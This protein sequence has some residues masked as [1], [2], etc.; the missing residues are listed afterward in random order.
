MLLD[1]FD[2]LLQAPSFGRSDFL[3]RLARLQQVQ[4]ASGPYALRT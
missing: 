3:I 1:G 2:E 4:A